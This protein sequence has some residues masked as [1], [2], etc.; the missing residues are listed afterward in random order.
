[1]KKHVPWREM[2]WA[3]CFLA[4][5]ALL[6]VPSYFAL[7]TRTTPIGT[8]RTLP[9]GD[10]LVT[11]TPEYRV[12]GDFV[13]SFF[14]PICKLDL[15]LRAEYWQFAVPTLFLA[16]IEREEELYKLQKFSVPYAK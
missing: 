2:G 12:G 4:G 14:R 13:G 1:M 16:T 9:S 6:Y 7:V 3:I 11:F 5:L 10:T 15:S 8:L